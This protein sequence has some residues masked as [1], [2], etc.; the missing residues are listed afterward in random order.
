MAATLLVAYCCLM[1]FAIVDH[2]GGAFKTPLIAALVA[3]AYSGLY[4]NACCMRNP[5]N[6]EG[7]LTGHH[8]LPAHIVTHLLF[9]QLHNCSYAVS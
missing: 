4:I 7:T 2:F 1:P 9:N 6:Y 5:F 8:T 3:Y